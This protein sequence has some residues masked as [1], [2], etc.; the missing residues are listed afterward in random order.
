[1]HLH[2]ITEFFYVEVLH[3]HSLRRA[4]R[5]LKCLSSTCVRVKNFISGND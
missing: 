5:E 4:K 2:K 1:M 3:W